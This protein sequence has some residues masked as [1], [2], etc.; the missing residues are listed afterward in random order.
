M[1]HQRHR[2]LAWSSHWRCRRSYLG[3]IFGR[4]WNG[5][6]SRCCR[7]EPFLYERR[8]EVTHRGQWWDWWFRTL[9]VQQWKRCLVPFAVDGRLKTVSVWVI[10]DVPFVQL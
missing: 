3:M 2:V 8:R 7:L 10:Y 6:D 9:T 5:G 4:W 1:S